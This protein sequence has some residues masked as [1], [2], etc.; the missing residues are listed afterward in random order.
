MAKSNERVDPK[1][2]Q[3]EESIPSLISFYNLL[4]LS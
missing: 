2:F 3:Q 1:K 4:I